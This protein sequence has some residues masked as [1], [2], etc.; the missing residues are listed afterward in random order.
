M[1]RIL[2]RCSFTGILFRSSLVQ[3]PREQRTKTSVKKVFPSL[4]EMWLQLKQ[5]G[6]E[7]VAYL[8]HLTC[9][10]GVFVI[11]SQVLF[12]FEVHRR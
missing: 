9:W 10:V 3:T 2:V 8:L 12:V 5:Y 7:K 6:S 11:S 1:Q 4:L